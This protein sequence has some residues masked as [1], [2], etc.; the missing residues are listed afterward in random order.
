MNTLKKIALEPMGDDDIKFYYPNSKIL[1]YPQ[2]KTYSSIE[3]L[4]PK[5]KSY[6]FLLYLQSENSGHWTLLS[7]NNNCIEFF[8]S[9][10]SSPS[11]PLKWTPENL[12]KQLKMNIPYLDILL[13]NT[14]MNVKYN[15]IDYQNKINLD[16]S[17]CGRHCVCRLNTILD[18]NMKLEEYYNMIQEIKKKT[19]KSY[20]DIVSSII[21]K[22]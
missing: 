8:C 12:R 1:T 18:D 3:E 10:G 20:D 4:L 13:S 17:T 19:N 6:C 9:Y 22:M 5:N 11:T 21:S 14:K 7:R 15:P 2:L 16:V